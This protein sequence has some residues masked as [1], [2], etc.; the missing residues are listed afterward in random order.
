M[1]LK[2]DGYQVSRV[3]EKDPAGVEYIPAEDYTAL[4]D[5]IAARK[6][7]C[8]EYDSEGNYHSEC[9][10]A[11]IFGDGGPVENEFEFCPYCGS[12]LAVLLD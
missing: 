12:R 11:F 5:W 10:N 1:W 8:W 6:T 4:L 9:G 7:C 3:S 2:A